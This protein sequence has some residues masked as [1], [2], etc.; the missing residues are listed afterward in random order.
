MIN[1]DK[2]EKV[3]EYK[4]GSL[5]WYTDKEENVVYLIRIGEESYIGSTKNLRRRFSQYVA[6]LTH[7]VYCSP[8]VQNAFSEDKSF[9]IYILERVPESGE[10]REREQFFIDLISP[11]LNANEKAYLSRGESKKEKCSILKVKEVIKAKGLTMQQVADVLGI[12][13]DT[14]T[15]NINGNPTIETL[16]KIAKALGVSVSDLLDEERPEEDKNTITCPHCGKNINI[17]VE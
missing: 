3:G 17:K 9:I 12:T 13:R 7:G 14:L 15:R 4:D 5:T 11:E 6:D 1:Y 8:R 16:E 10:I 2:L